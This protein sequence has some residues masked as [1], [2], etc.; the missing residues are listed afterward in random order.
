MKNITGTEF[1][2]RALGAVCLLLV[3][4]MQGTSSFKNLLPQ[5]AVLVLSLT[6]IALFCTAIYLQRKR[7]LR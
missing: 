2:F 1:L 4:L 5:W 6:A 7:E 3:I